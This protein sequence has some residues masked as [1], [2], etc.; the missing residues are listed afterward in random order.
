MRYRQAGLT[1]VEFAI[2][3]SLLFVLLFGIIEFGRAMYI[4]NAL[5]EGT[6]RAARLAAVCPVGDNKA[7]QA[8]IFA[9]SGSSLIAPN[10]STGNVSI[11]YLND[12]GAV[13]TNTTA[14]YLLIRYVRV[15][16]TG[17]SVALNI[18]FINPTLIVPPLTATLPRES[19]GYFPT[20]NSFPPC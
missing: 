7:A 6:R 17:Y 4:Y 3:G 13:I 19:L 11:A 16:I 8:A 10:L 20:S 14:N 12:A 18:P 9:E 2:V 5:T 1:T 15:Q